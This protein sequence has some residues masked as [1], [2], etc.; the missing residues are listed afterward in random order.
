MSR[1]T[2]ARSDA[3]HQIVGHGSAQGA[4]QTAGDAGVYPERMPQ[5]TAQSHS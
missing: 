3:L 5:V 4:A 2:S 1:T